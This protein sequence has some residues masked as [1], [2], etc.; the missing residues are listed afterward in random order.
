MF[1]KK[2]INKK[3]NSIVIDNKN[4]ILNTKNINSNFKLKKNSIIN[5]KSKIKT[6]ENDSVKIEETNFKEYLNTSLDDL[7]YD[8][9]VE[10]DKRKLCQI[11]SDIVKNDNMMIRTFF[12]SDN[13]RPKSIKILLFVLIINLYLVINALMYNEEYIS[14]L[15][16][17]NENGNFLN[18][19]NNSNDRLLSVSAIG[20]II[21]YLIEFYFL[22][23]KKL[24]RI[25]L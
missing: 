4:C 22:D 12:I 14:E 20:I 9:A 21:S 7:E 19:L 23:E 13:V 24:K 6:K 15:Y 17:S 25:F 3:R 1:N 2:N 18:F 11:F 10:K 5:F 16:N 8:E